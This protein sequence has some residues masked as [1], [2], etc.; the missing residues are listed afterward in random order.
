MLVSLLEQ[1]DAWMGNG[2]NLRFSVLT[3]AQLLRAQLKSNTQTK[4]NSLMY[5]IRQRRMLL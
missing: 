1:T 2:W 3:P 4:I 5:S